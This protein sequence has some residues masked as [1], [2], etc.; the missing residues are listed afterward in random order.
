MQETETKP[1]AMSLAEAIR[2]RRSVRGFTDRPVPAETLRS[3]F[4]LAQQTPSNCNI[5][6]WNVYVASGAA[7]DRI[8]QGLLKKA[9]AGETPDPDYKD[10]MR[11]LEGVY[12]K[13][14]IECAVALYGEMKIAREDLEGR[15]RA[16]LRNFELFD[17]PHVAYIGMDKKFGTTVA[18]DVGGYL[19][20][21]ML[22]MTAHGVASCPQASLRNYNEVVREEFGIGTEIGILV[23]LSFGYE[24]EST[25]ANRTR[26]T[27]AELGENVIFRD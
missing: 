16:A 13:R 4:E 24:D 17:A 7:R 26:T 20:T 11:S 25:P 14:Q 21:L 9:A 27:R 19:Q 5:Q 23:G 15:K 3:I 12:R 6:P 1:E 8:R 10:Y 2:T 18:L 22:S